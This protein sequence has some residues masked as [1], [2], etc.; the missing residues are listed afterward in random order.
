MLWGPYQGR[1]DAY[2]EP[3]DGWSASVAKPIT[4]PYSW[5][6][7]ASG[8]WRYRAPVDSAYDDE[9]AH[10]LP[11]LEAFQT[12]GNLPVA[13]WFIPTDDGWGVWL[14]QRLDMR[15]VAR[16]LAADLLADRVLIGDDELRCHHCRVSVYGADS[17]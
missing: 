1:P 6:A 15:L 13:Q 9:R 11:L 17:G 14:R 7:P 3:S 5:L 16:H 2:A 12:S 10:L 8:G 4:Q